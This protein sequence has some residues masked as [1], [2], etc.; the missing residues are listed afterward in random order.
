MVLAK[1]QITVESTLNVHITNET[2]RLFQSCV[3]CL[4]SNNFFHLDPTKG[5]GKET[6]DRVS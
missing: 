6:L 2:P 5:E 3:F 4:M 1:K